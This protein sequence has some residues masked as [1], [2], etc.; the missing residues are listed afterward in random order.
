MIYTPRADKILIMVLYI[1]QL[2]RCKCYQPQ[3]WLDINLVK[4]YKVDEIY[5]PCI[6]QSGWSKFTTMVQFRKLQS[7]I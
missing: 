6:E 4:T 5:Q 2:K 7:N 3:D 1:C